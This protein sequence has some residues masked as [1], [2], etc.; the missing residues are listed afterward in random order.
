LEDKKI[1]QQ[2]TARGI[3]LQLELAKPSSTNQKN[4]VVLQLFA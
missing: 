2:L 3:H 1:W 4:K